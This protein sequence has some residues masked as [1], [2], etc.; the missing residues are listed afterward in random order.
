MV[1]VS[2]ALGASGSPF[3]ICR[4]ARHNEVRVTFAAYP[5]VTV[6]KSRWL[7]ASVVRYFAPAQRA[8]LV[9]PHGLHSARDDLVRS[10]FS[11]HAPTIVALL[12]RRGRTKRLLP[13]DPRTI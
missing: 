4:Y 7:A 1:M 9:I 2:I 6:R 10:C 3:R 13:P 8:V 12:D 11:D 5:L